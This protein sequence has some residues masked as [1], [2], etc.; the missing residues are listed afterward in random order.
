MWGWWPRLLTQPVTLIPP[1]LSLLQTLSTQ[2]RQASEQNQ[3]KQPWTYRLVQF[4]DMLL[5]HS[6]NV[7]PLTPFTTQQ[8]Q[9][10]NR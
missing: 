5:N 6:R 3:D 9:A 2:F 7:T 10:W 8:R 1:T 4:A